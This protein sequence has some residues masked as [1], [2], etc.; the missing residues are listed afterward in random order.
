MSEPRFVRKKLADKLDPLIFEKIVIETRALL[1]RRFES[2]AVDFDDIS[3]TNFNPLLLLITA[4]VYNLQSPFE[5]AERLQLAKAYH[6]DDTAFGKFGEEKLLPLFGV[7]PIELKK[8]KTA[9]V[10]EL[11]SPV[12]AEA[13]IEG[14]DYFMSIKSGPWTMN[15]S[16][17]NE[18]IK[19]FPQ[20]H[21]ETG[22]KVFIGLLYGTRSQLNNKPELVAR[23]IGH[24]DW[25]DYLVGRECWEFIS[26]VKDVH[27][28]IYKAI[29]QAQK[30]FSEAHKDETFNE[31]LIANRLK[32]AAS[33]RKKFDIDEE[34]DFWWTLFN[35]AF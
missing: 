27:R 14:K 17:A 20:V 29:R 8:S 34:E 6:G 9:A 13:A 26:G 28:E 1:D 15:Q 4:P 35:G 5:V 24:P 23:S 30:E 21:K 22:K 33:L 32:I 12:D 7:R 18:M 25:F 16:H 31:K 3:K 10:K 11:W 19:S 2:L